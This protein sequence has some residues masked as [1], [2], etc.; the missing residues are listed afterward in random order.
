MPIGK[1]SN[2]RVSRK[3]LPIISSRNPLRREIT[4]EEEEFFKNRTGPQGPRKVAT[5]A[6]GTKDI[7]VVIDDDAKFVGL[8]NKELGAV[9]APV[10]DGAK[11]GYERLRGH[12]PRPGQR[13]VLLLDRDLSGERFSVNLVY[14]RE[15]IYKGVEVVAIS[16]SSLNGTK[17][18]RATQW[19]DGFE[20][21]PLIEGV[22]PSIAAIRACMDGSCDCAREKFSREV[23]SAVWRDATGMFGHEVRHLAGDMKD[24]RKYA[25]LCECSLAEAKEALA[26]LEARFLRT[27][28][29]QVPAILGLVKDRARGEQLIEEIFHILGQYTVG[30]KQPPAG[31]EER[32]EALLQQ[33]EEC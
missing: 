5:M 33:L 13:L 25:K 24:L 26:S 3:D 27:A 23:A 31:H 20:H 18:G 6:T 4:T 1:Y 8:C 14:L 9:G 30:M 29:Q 11:G 28:R 21:R 22:K 16:T 12:K 32:I 17:A 10:T 2:L 19:A 7:I 15:E